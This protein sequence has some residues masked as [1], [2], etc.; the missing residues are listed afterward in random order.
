M[1]RL[2]FA[3]TALLI[4]LATVS[5]AEELKIVGPVAKIQTEAGKATVVIKDNAS[6]KD[7][8]ITVTDQLTVDKLND[9]RI[10]VGDEVRVKYDTKDNVSKLFRKTAGC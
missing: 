7:V 4:S 5:F 3:I 6:G 9:K 10:T 2:I 1:K 8:A